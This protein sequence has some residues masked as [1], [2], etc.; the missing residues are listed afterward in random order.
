MTFTISKYARFE[1]KKKKNKINPR[2]LPVVF[3]EIEEEGVFFKRA[4]KREKTSLHRDNVSS[5]SI[6]R[7]EIRTSVEKLE[8][9]PLLDRLIL[10]IK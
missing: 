2:N 10:E 6:E 1:K 4:F 7:K 8:N 3:D 5:T 9:F